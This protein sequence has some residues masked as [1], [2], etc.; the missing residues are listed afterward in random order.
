M[1]IG[2]GSGSPALPLKLALPEGLALTMV[3]SKARKSA[4]LR[5]AIRVL[6]VAPVVV[7]TARYEELLS[8]A[9]LHEV[10][11]VVT[12]R[13]VR[14]EART[15]RSVQA[16]LKPGGA[17]LLFRGATGPERPETLVPPLEFMQTA[18]LLESNQSRL[19]VLVKHSVGVPRGTLGV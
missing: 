17:I 3:E 11:D 9:D 6:G 1:D 19:T 16:F 4:F 2:S 13:A 5:E 10:F 12:L 14:I 15:L 18:P 7:E 8:R